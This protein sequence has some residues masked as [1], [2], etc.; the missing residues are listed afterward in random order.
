MDYLK[1]LLNASLMLAFIF[2]G[3]KSAPQSD[4]SKEDGKNKQAIARLF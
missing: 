4:D 3:L 2:L 1:W